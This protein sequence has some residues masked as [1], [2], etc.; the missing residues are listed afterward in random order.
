MERAQVLRRWV[1]GALLLVL[2]GG[3]FV[4]LAPGPSTPLGRPVLVEASDSDPLPPTNVVITPGNGEFTRV[5]WTASTEPNRS[6]YVVRL[7]SYQTTVTGTS[8]T[9]AITGLTNGT[10]Y[11]VEVYT[12]TSYGFLNLASATGTVPATATSYPRDGVAPAAPTGVTAVRGDGRVTVSW[13]ANTESD[14]AGYRVLRDGTPVS[15]TLTART[16]TDTGLVNDTTYR[17]TVQAVDV[18]RQWSA[19]SSP[20]V[21]ATPTDLTPPATPTGFLAERGDSQVTLSWAA[22]TEPDLAG[23][24]VLRNG[25]EVG[26]VPAGTQAW[27]DTGLTNDTTYQYAVLAVDTH[28]NRSAP[29]SSVNA[30]PTDLTAPSAPTGLTATRG[31]GRVDLTWTANPE[32]DLASYRLLRDGQEVAVIAAGTTSYA[33]TGLVNDRSYAYRLAAV[34]TH[35][36]RSAPSAAVTATP[37][38]LTPPAPPT[39]LAAVRGDGQVALTW[40]ANSEADLATYRV[41]RDGTEVATVTGTSYTDTGLVNDRSYAYRVV[42][43]DTHGN[44]S[45][46]SAA[47]SATPTD[48]TPPSAPTGLVAVRGDGQVALTWT[49]NPETDV[50]TYRVLR[51]STEVATVTG[52]SYT[53]TG[54][55]NDRSY[56]YRVVAV[57]THGNRSAA[58]DPTVT[59]TPTD[60]TPPAAPTGLAAARGDG[61]VTLSWTANPEPDLASYRVLRDGTEV[62]TVTGATSW[63]DTAVVNDTAYTYRLVAVDTHGNRSAPSTAVSATPTDLTAPGTPTGFT[64]VRGDGRVDLTWT[65]NPETDVVGYRLFRDGVLLATVSGTSWTDTAVTN[66]VTYAYR[67]AAVDGHGNVGV[68]TAA[69]PATP[70]DLT[71]PAVPT[72]LAATRGD[73]QVVLTWTAN[74]EPDLASYRVLRDGTEIATV[75]GT[76]YTATGLT[77]DRATS[78]ALVAVD[79]H[80]NRSAASAPVGATPTDLTAPGAPTGVATDRG[81][82]QVTLS[83]APSPEPDVVGYRVLRDGVQVATVTGTTYTDT[84]LTNDTVHRYSVVAVDGHGNASGPSAGVDGTPTDLTAPAAP[85]AL[86]AQRG[87]GQVVLSWAAGTEPDLASYAVLRDGVQVGTVTGTSFTD[88]G[89]TNDT[90]Y[91]YAVVAVDGHGNRSAQATVTATPTDLT[92]PAAPTAPTATAGERTVTVTW[93]APADTDVVGYRVLRGGAVVAATTGASATVTGLAPG[94]AVD[95]QV[96]AVDG[97]G[98]VSPVSATVTATPYDS[99]APAAPTALAARPGN[100][101]VTLTWTAPADVDPLTYRVLRDGVQVATVT[102]TSATDGGLVNGTSYAYTVQA[103]DPSGNVSPVSATVVVVPVVGT[104][105]AAGSG[106]T[107]ALAVSSDGRYVVTGT[108]ARLEASD[109]NT[110]YELY[111][112]DRVAGTATRIAPLPASATAA[113]A[114]NSAA[115]AISDDGRYVALATTAA[116]VPADTNGRAD[117][118]RL[119]TVTGTWALVSVPAGG[120]VNA[121]VAGTVLQT[122][123]AVYATSPAVV[124]SGDGD[125]VLFYSARNDLG[126]VD[127]NGV[128]DLYAK[129]LSTGA[130]TRVSATASGGELTR[131]VAG[132]ALAI[133][134][135]GRYTLFPATGSGGPVVLYR[136]TLTGGADPVVVSTVGSTPVAVARDTGDVDI[137]DDGRYVV[138]STSAKPTAP[139]SSWS[140]QLAYRKDTVTGAVAALGDGQTGAWEHQLALD[141]TGRYAFFTTAAAPT[142]DTNGHT[143]TFRRDLVTGTLTLVTADADGRPVSGPTGAVAPTEYGRPVAVTGDLVVLTTSQ[144]LLPADTNRLRDLYVK[145]L[146]SGVVQSP[147]PG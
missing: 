66:D 88:T 49:A 98:N 20:A 140:T 63:T 132:P 18:S 116:L 142:G 89:L 74:T 55:V 107:G 112:I 72:G 130:V 69:V 96:V 58:S 56:A 111:R 79:T 146:G 103:V 76:T 126:P 91:R 121:S 28:G 47:V 92:P 12:R 10:D 97:H 37:T 125:L 120:R 14:L 26:I 53:D 35:A 119:D 5:S 114:T 134:P 8:T 102:G 128:V 95:L 43:V 85:A 22:N 108:R 93:T 143:D 44:R 29:T 104:V 57:D 64:A 21:A 24:R 99:T 127:G 86:T 71:P 54:L 36:N 109:T 42:A 23:Y 145:D 105:P 60:F 147:V 11:T 40:T 136:A 118:Y 84:G 4:A 131:Q 106:D 83:W 59:A 82:G 15:G 39:G 65:A 25:V 48:L 45:V 73:G 52:T 129:R 13:A 27:T 123:S 33:D 90:A 50:A 137:S 75:T 32:P 3:A 124:I 110:A 117:V 138:F 81:D 61:R 68:A 77:N 100:T 139:T 133:T 30:T 7:G 34:D 31:D 2:L 94:T 78:F 115:P 19:S 38:D 141:P 46:P 113:D 62:A 17:Y 16:Y 101:A 9:A 1:R 51:D 6:G 87:D 70:T 144:A 80:G 41:L 122:A 135:D 67:L